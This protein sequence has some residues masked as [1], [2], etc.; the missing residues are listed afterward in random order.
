MVCREGNEWD[1][2]CHAMRVTGGGG[3]GREKCTPPTKKKKTKINPSF[4]NKGDKKNK[5]SYRPITNL[6]TALKVFE[7]LSS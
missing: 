6:F 3:G 4:Q 2:P 1:V 5:E 7:K